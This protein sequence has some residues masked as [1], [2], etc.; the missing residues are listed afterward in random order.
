LTT[1]V[2]ALITATII[3]TVLVVV[4]VVAVEKIRLSELRG[5]KLVRPLYAGN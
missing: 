2:S 1:T 4:V 3:I 5:K